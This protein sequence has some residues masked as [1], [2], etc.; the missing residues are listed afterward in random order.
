MTLVRQLIWNKQVNI[1]VRTADG[2]ILQQRDSALAHLLQDPSAMPLSS[3]DNYSNAH[4]I[5]LQ[6][7]IFHKPQ[8]FHNLLNQAPHP[9]NILLQ[10]LLTYIDSWN[11]S[12]SILKLISLYF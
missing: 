8:W 9:N 3:P 7:P 2:G 10:F 5:C 6:S 4:I 1:G 12:E 11:S